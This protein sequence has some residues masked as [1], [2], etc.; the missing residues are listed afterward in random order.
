MKIKS[1][2]EISLFSVPIKES[3]IIGFFLGASLKDEVLKIMPMQKQTHAGQRT[4]FKA[5]VIT[6][7]YN[8]H[9]GLGVTRCTGSSHC[10]PWSHYP[11]QALGEKARQASHVPCK[12]TAAVALSWCA[13]P[14][15]LGQCLGPCVKEV[16]D[17]GRASARGC[18]AT[19]GNFAKATFDAISKTYS[20][21][22]PDLR[23]ETLLN[24]F[25]YQEFTLL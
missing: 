13:S 5:F 10:H 24:K 16:V 20:Y 3:E 22:T 23:N 19:L 2:E 14:L 21:L 12:V 4:R 17:D 8:G 25:S 7:N 11:G 15:P 18:T 6:G 1:L 9:V